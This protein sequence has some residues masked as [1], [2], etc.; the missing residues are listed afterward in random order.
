MHLL[1]FPH[2]RPPL[3]Y[4]QAESRSQVG[5]EPAPVGKNEDG[6]VGD[7]DLS[8]GM[9]GCE[10]C[11]PRDHHQLVAGLCSTGQGCVSTLAAGIQG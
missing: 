8:C 6:T 1:S 2:P 11:I 10:G 3:T 9:A 5:A 4:R 7:V